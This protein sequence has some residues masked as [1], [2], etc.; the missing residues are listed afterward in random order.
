MK[1]FR[2]GRLGWDCKP[3]RLDRVKNGQKQKCQTAHTIR[4]GA[5]RLIGSAIA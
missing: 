4:Y 1:W 5:R 3:R 2:Q